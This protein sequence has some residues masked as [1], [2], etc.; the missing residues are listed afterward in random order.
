MDQDGSDKEYK[1]MLLLYEERT[2]QENRRREKESGN[3]KDRM[4]DSIKA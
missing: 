2:I 3:Q 1:C 4:I